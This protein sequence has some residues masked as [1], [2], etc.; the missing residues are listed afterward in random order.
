MRLTICIPTSIGARTLVVQGQDSETAKAVA[1]A[2]EGYGCAVSLDD[3]GPR[4]TW[5]EHLARVKREARKA[6]LK[7]PRVAAVQV[8]S[9]VIDYV[10]AK[11]SVTK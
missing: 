3:D 6:A 1:S 8:V 7:S 4:V 2:L 5:P 10:K 11:R 9:P